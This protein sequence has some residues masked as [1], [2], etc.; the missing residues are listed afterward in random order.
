MTLLRTTRANRGTLPMPIARITLNTPDPKNGDQK[1]GQEDE[2]EGE[3]AVHDA[4]NDRVDDTAHE[5]GDEAQDDADDAAKH[6]RADG[7]DDTHARTV[8]DAVEQVAAQI[9][10]AEDMVV[11]AGLEI[12]LGNRRGVR[13]ERRDERAKM[14]IVSITITMMILMT[15]DLFL[16]NC[17]MRCLSQASII[18]LGGLG[19]GTINDFHL[20]PE[21]A[22]AADFSLTL[23]APFFASAAT[24]G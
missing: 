10:G 6:R 5:A 11:H 12:G 22:A 1:Q 13:V 2:R 16:D 17:A 4:H 23:L 3:Q 8:D 15:A 9:V 18:A 14:P 21:V 19:D 24:W 7:D 20:G